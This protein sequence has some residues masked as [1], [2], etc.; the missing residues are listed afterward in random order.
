[1]IDNAFNDAVD[2]T[3]YKL[4]IDDKY[5]GYKDSEDYY[6]QKYENIVK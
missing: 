6:K 2:D 5:I 1:M 4:G 3:S